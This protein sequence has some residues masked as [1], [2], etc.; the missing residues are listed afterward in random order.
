[1]SHLV[2]SVHKRRV[3]VVNSSAI[4]RSDN[5]RCDTKTVKAGREILSVN[6]PHFN[7]I[8]EK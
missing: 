5:S 1:M 8:K 3:L 6:S 2:C 4:H 7:H